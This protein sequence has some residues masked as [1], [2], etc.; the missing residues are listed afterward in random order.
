MHGV[1]CTT[2]F[3]GPW[4][5]VS[6]PVSQRIGMNSGVN[7]LGQGNRANATIGRA[8]QLII[9]NVG[10][11]RPGEID[12]STLG[13]PGKLGACFAENDD[14]PLWEPLGVRRGFDPEASTVT[15]F[16][17][18]GVQP[19]W[20][21]R[22]RSPESLADSF[23]RSVS[24]IGHAKRYQMHDV[25][26]VISPDH[27]RIFAE[28]NWTADQIAE[29]INLRTALFCTDLARGAGD[30]AEGLLPAQ[31]KGDT[32]TKFSSISQM[33]L[34]RAGGPAGLMSAIISGWAASGE[35]GSSPVTTEIG[36]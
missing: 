24:V 6:G 29:E 19:V 30:N 16:A 28:S 27:H 8:L 33:I 34:V 7:A 20:D 32:M 11:G 36:K 3:V 23:A 9:R 31:L 25:M 5:I 18:A 21:E 10:G 35:R 4:L 22:S 14:H 15:A 13:H 12:R 2:D 1:L 26:I 17:G